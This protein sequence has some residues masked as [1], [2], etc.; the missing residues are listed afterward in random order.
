MWKECLGGCV[1]FGPNALTRHAP[2]VRTQ[3]ITVSRSAHLHKGM[4]RVLKHG[5]S[6]GISNCESV[7]ELQSFF[8]AFIQALN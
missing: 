3:L 1:L 5:G 8:H 4:A 6:G 7:V 2:L